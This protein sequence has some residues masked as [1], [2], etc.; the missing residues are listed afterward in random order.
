MGVLGERRLGSGHKK[1]AGHAQVNNPL[2][3][4]LLFHS[5]CGVTLCPRAKFHHDVLSGAVD[6]EE[7]A[8]FEATGLSR[9]GG[10]ERFTMGGK[11]HID[12]A[13]AANAGIHTAGDGLH[14]GQFGHALILWEEKNCETV[15]VGLDVRC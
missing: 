4:D 15:D 14:L 5:R 13:V 3:F 1:P 7:T 11:P 2:C 8:A 12:D 10:F 6:G 9:G